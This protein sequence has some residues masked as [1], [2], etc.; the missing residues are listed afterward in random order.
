MNEDLIA[1]ITTRMDGAEVGLRPYKRKVYELRRLVAGD[2]SNALDTPAARQDASGDD[3]VLRL[4]G[5][6]DFIVTDYVD[7]HSNRLLQTIKQL[8][9]QIAYT[10]PDVEFEDLTSLEAT[11]NAGWIK[12]RLAPAPVGCGARDAM[13]LG[14]LDFMIGGFGWSYV[15]M[16]GGTPSVDYCDTLDMKWDR[17]ARHPSEMKWASCR[18]I[19]TCAEWISMFGAAAF[20]DE[21]GGDIANLDR[22]VAM[23]FYYDIDT[24]K[25]GEGTFAVFKAGSDGCYGDPVYEGKNPN[26]FNYGERSLPFLPFTPTYFMM[27]PSCKEPIGIVEMMLPD[28]L[29]LWG[30]EEYRS[31]ARRS[32][33][34][35]YQIPDGILDAKEMERF[36][37]GDFGAAI[38]TKGAGVIT[39]NGGLGVPADIFQEMSLLERQF[40]A[41]SG[42]NPYANGVP[43]EGI[44]YA[45]EVKEISGM[46]GLTVS[47]AAED[48]ASWWRETMRKFLAIGALYDDDPITIRMGEVPMVFGGMRPIKTFLRPDADI[49]VAA[50]KMSFR[51]RAQRIAEA[52][53][54]LKVAAEVAAFFPQALGK[55]YEKYLRAAGEKDVAGWMQPPPQMAAP[56]DTGAPMERGV[57]GSPADVQASTV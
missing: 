47:F 15:C 42:L 29:A 55:A 50:D 26:Q 35:F 33:K 17:Q 18:F 49:V 44:E 14:L 45:A 57:G 46:S 2:F 3:P 11:V 23:E 16:H 40:I 31:R 7:N 25:D 32:G 13:K 4:D 30:I 37:D 36:L 56:M 28:Q 24:G 27:L 53:R 10:E 38:K 48:H 22:S 19:Q 9:M 39:P 21:Y 20:E 1:R 6:Y 12:Q 8:M 5:M 52:Q 34:P 51:P 41:N 54:D 43:V